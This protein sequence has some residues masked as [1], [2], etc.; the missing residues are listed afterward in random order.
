MD[1]RKASIL[2]WV[3]IVASCLITYA[4]YNYAA[5]LAF[6]GRSPLVWL[7]TIGFLGAVGLVLIAIV[8]RARSR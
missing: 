6:S 5:N 1:K 8:L 2:Y 4:S 7:S 3:C